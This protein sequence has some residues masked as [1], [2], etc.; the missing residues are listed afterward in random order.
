MNKH[1]LHSIFVK[2]AKNDFKV[3][4]KTSVHHGMMLTG[5]R[6]EELAKLGITKHTMLKAEKRKWVIKQYFKEK[7]EKNI[8]FAYLWTLDLPQQRGWRRIIQLLIDLKEKLSF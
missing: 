3:N 2:H 5:M 4:N 8:K 7:G 1:H 6:P